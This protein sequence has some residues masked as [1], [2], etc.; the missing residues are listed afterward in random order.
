MSRRYTPK[1]SRFFDPI[2]RTNHSLPLGTVIGKEMFRRPAFARTLTNRTISG[3]DGSAANGLSL[4][5]RRRSRPSQT[6]TCDPSGSLRRNSARNLIRDPGFRTTSVP[7]APTFVTSYS[8]SSLASMLGRT[9]LCPPT[10]MPRKKTMRAI[11]CLGRAL[12]IIEG[13]GDG[14][15]CIFDFWSLD[16]L[17]LWKRRSV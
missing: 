5:N 13:N 11:P 17:K 6:T 7:A 8:R 9:L 14:G 10:L 1:I 16:L 2:M 3:R 4:S 12:C 15:V